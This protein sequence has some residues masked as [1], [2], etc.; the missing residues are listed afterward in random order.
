MIIANLLA[1]TSFII[2]NK[3]LIKKLGLAEAVLIGELCSEHNYWK[4]KRGLLD[5]GWFFS[6]VAN[7][8]SETGIK[9]STQTTLL[10]KLKEKG[11]LSFKKAGIPPRRY[12]ALDFNA[13]GRLIDDSN[14]CDL[15]D[16]QPNVSRQSTESQSNLEPE[17]SPH[18]NNKNKNNNKNNIIT[19]ENV[20]H[21]CENEGLTGMS[22]SPKAFAEWFW[23]VAHNKDGSLNYKGTPIRNWAA[24]V[25]VLRGVDLN[26]KKFKKAKSAY[27][28]R[29]DEGYF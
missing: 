27:K 17:A 24:L 12:V 26:G 25:S 8:E 16:D 11:L 14:D 20:A 22:E 19:L 18:N 6:T 9:R 13:I 3:T 5:G 29:E 21:V 4:S 15:V 1:S 28:P 7:V 10:T 2:A 23:G